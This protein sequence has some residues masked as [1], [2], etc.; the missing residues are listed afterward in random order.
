MTLWEQFLSSLTPEQIVAGVAI[1]GRAMIMALVVSGLVQ[2][3]IKQNLPP[4]DERTPK[5]RLMISGS[6]LVLSMLFSFGWALF[7][8]QLTNINGALY[9]IF[10]GAVTT[11]FAFGGYEFVKTLFRFVTGMDNITW[12][13][14]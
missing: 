14:S 10:V 12:G 1:I 11:L 4:T 9:S 5:Q 13:K 3:F 8:G 7:A 2:I 6:V